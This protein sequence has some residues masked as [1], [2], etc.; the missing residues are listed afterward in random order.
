[1]VLKNRY[2]FILEEM[3]LFGKMGTI[4]IGKKREFI[5]DVFGEIPFEDILIGERASRYI[6][7]GLA[8]DYYKKNDTLFNFSLNNDILRIENANK[9]EGIIVELFSDAELFYEPAEKI[10]SLIL[11]QGIDLFYNDKLSGDGAGYLYIT[12]NN[13]K[14]VF[15]PYLSKFYKKAQLGYLGASMDCMSQV[16]SDQ[17]IKITQDNMIVPPFYH[18]LRDFPKGKKVTR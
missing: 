9:T 7:L 10:F 12:S 1:M 6:D 11:D 3:M 18:E 8:F 5:E 17:V 14:L 15:N 2:N 4:E 13:V 16:K